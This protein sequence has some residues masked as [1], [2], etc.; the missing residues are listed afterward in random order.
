MKFFCSNTECGC[1]DYIGL[2]KTN[3]L[4]AKIM[5]IVLFVSLNFDL[6]AQKNRF[7]Q[8]VRLITHDI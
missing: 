4:L 1:Y 2:D 5:N 8:I 3:K 6:G 7:I